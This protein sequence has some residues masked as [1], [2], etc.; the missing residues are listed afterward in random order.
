MGALHDNSVRTFAYLDAD[1]AT[2][3]FGLAGSTTSWS[4]TPAE[5]ATTGE[6]QS[7]LFARDGIASTLPVARIGEAFEDALEAF[8]G[9]LLVAAV[10]VLA[11]ALLIAFNATRITVEE[12][13][14]DH[15]TMRAFDFRPLHPRHDH[16]GEHRGRRARHGRRCHCRYRHA[17]LDAELTRTTHAAR[18]RY[19]PLHRAATLGW[20]AGIGI[21]AVSLAL[22]FLVRRIRNMD[23]PATLRA[24]EWNGSVTLPADYAREHVRLGYAATAHTATS[25]R[26][27]TTASASSRR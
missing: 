16:Q 20:A 19:R 7:A 5:S 11:L 1:A 17:R 4:V 2:E 6:L 8:T 12:R 3:L 21:I 15:A 23:V 22:L 10:A 14:R 26:R 24:M 9:F 27:S 18:V 25:P 13:Q